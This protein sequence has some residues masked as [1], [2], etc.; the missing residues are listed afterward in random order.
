L[1]FKH[2]IS[3]YYLM[4]MEKQVH[5][6]TVMVLLIQRDGIIMERLRKCTIMLLVM[7][8]SLLQILDQG[9]KQSKGR[10]FSL[11]IYFLFFRSDRG[12]CFFFGQIS[13]TT[14]MWQ[15]VNLTNTI[16]PHLI[17]N[18]VVKFNL[19]AWIGGWSSQNDNAQVS[20]IFFDQ[21]NQIIGSQTTIGPVLAADRGSQSS[22]LFRQA[23]DYVPIGARSFTVIVLITCSVSPSNDGSIDNIGIYLYT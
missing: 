11:E 4:V 13:T 3:I 20:V 14:S 22:L 19:S 9:T 15:T 7:G 10:N 16:D 1:F 18:H 17:D 2:S 8:L 23:N 21:T 12:N 5:V 6:K